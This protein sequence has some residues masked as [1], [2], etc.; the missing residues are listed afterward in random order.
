VSGIVA[1]L[2]RLAA[3]VRLSSVLSE[4]AGADGGAAPQAQFKPWPELSWDDSTSWRRGLI[5]DDIPVPDDAPGRREVAVVRMAAPLMPQPSPG[6]RIRVG[7]SLH[8][9]ALAV[10]VDGAE[11][12]IHDKRDHVI[13]LRLGLNSLHGRDDTTV[14]LHNIR[15]KG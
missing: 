2:R 11:R 4:V 6:R 1:G 10:P 9:E 7:C 8:R 3:R 15:T 14:D 5:V 13:F 12:L